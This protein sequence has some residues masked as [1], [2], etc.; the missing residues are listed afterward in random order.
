MKSHFI[1]SAAF[2][3]VGISAEL[4][5]SVGHIQNLQLLLRVGGQ[6]GICSSS[7]LLLLFVKYQR[8]QFVKMVLVDGNGS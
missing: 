4:L 3:A 8:H 1:S 7:K 2:R 5:A 6:V